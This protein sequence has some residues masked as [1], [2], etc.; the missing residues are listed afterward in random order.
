MIVIYNMLW[1][2]HVWE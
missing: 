2:Q 1:W